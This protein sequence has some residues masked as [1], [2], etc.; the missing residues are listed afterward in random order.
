MKV[1]LL[2]HTQLSG[3]FLDLMEIAIGV[4]DRKS[5]V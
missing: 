3:E 4:R 5:V 2:A 1:T